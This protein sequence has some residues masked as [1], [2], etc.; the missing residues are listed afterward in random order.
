MGTPSIHPCRLDGRVHAADIQ[1]EDPATPELELSPVSRKHP[2]F[3]RHV[4]LQEWHAVR[5]AA[6]T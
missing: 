4:L 6:H 2:I 3:R 1:G 5:R